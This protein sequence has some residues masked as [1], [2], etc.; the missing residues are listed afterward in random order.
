MTTQRP[1]LNWMAWLM[2]ILGGSALFSSQQTITIHV[3]QAVTPPSQRMGLAKADDPGTEAP[4]EVFALSDPSFDSSG[5]QVALWEFAQSINGGEHFP[6]F[7]QET[8]DC[9]AQGAANAINYLQAVQIA[10]HGQ[11]ARFRCAFAP[12]IY[13]VSRTAEDIGAGRLRRSAGSVGSWAA[14]AV[15]RYGVLAADVPGVPEYSGRISDQWGYQGPPAEYFDEAEDF[16]VETVAQVNSYEDVRDALANGYPVTVASNQ[17]FR[18]QAKVHRGKAFGMP[19]GQWAHQMCL[20]AVDDQADCPDGSKGACYC[21]NSWGSAA[22]G[23]PAGDEPPGGFWISR[24]VVERMVR[25]GDSWAYSNFSGFP[26]RDLDFRI[27]GAT[28]EQEQDLVEIPAPLPLVAPACYA[29]LGI[30]RPLAEAAGG[31]CL[32]GSAGAMFWRRRRHT[33]RTQ[34]PV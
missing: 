31:V 13:G 18:M 23:P 10:S 24:R 9:V 26:L 21:L 11:S 16:V 28:A 15:E 17:G 20:I 30:E 32:L 4:V 22:H 29:W 2:A 27:F 12:W 7:R 33:R 6:T 8:G 5:A 19:S 3:D 1:G 25:Q 34:L 14:N